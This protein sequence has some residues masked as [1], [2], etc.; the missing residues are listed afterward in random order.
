[1]KQLVK[2]KV[3]GSFVGWV[4][5][6]SADTHRKKRWVSLTLHPSYAGIGAHRLNVLN[7]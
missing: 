4:E 5:A 1:M 7:L 3:N 2:L 6:Q